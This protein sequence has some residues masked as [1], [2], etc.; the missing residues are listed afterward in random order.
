MFT[1]TYSVCAHTILLF[2]FEFSSLIL[3]LL[4]GSEKH[5]TKFSVFSDRHSHSQTQNLMKKCLLKLLVLLCLASAPAVAQTVSGRVTNSAD[6]TALPGVSVLVKG[7]SSGTTTDFDGKYTIGAS[8]PNAVLVFSFIGFA[9]QEIPLGSRTSVDVVLEEDIT[10]LG[11]VVVTALGIAKESKS[12]GYAV[13]KVEGASMTQ[14]REVNFVNSLAGRVAGVS[15]SN[16]SGGPGS[17]SNVRIRG[18]SSMFSDNSPLYVINGVPINNS[19]R[20]SAGMWGGADLGDGI[21]NI[22]PDDIEEMTVLKGS[23]ASAL[24][25]SRAANGVVVIT[26]KKGKAGAPVVEFNSNYTVDRIIDLTDY[27]DQYGQGTMGLK[28]T[29]SDAAYHAG[30]NSWGGKLDGSSVPQFDGIS[31]PY[32]AQRDNLKDFY[33]T[34]NTFTNTIALSAGNDFTSFRLSVSDLNN[35][36]VVPNSGLHRNTFNISVDQ[37]INSKFKASLLANYINEKSDNRP[38][39]SDSPGNS[40]FG[41]MFLPTSMSHSVLA[42]GFDEDGAE[43]NHTDNVYLTNPYFAANRF[44]NDLG[45]KRLISALTLKYDITKDLYIQGRVTRDS[46]NDRQ[47]SI[48]PTGTAYYPKGNMTEVASEGTDL[49]ADV[50]AAYKRTIVSDLDADLTV[51]ANIR[52]FDTEIITSSGDQFSIPFLHVLDNAIN[53]N[54][55]Y[56]NPRGEVQSWY[57]SLGFSYKNT[58]FLNTTGRKDYFSTL[59]S[60]SNSLFYPSV[61]ASVVFSEWISSN[62]F[63]FG[64]LRTSWAQTSGMADPY[65]TKLYYSIDQSI[66]G[67]PIGVIGGNQVPNGQLKPYSLNEFELGTE[68]K[69]LENRITFDVAYFSRKTKD[70]IVNR[71]VSQTS[72]YSSAVVNLGEWQNKGVELMVAADIVKTDKF[73]WNLAFNFTKMNSE[74][75]KLSDIA[76]DTISQL[77]QSRTQ[78]AYVSQVVGEEISQVMAYDFLRNPSGDII[79]DAA[80]RPQR[81]DL[82]PMGSGMHHTY[83]G[84]NNEFTYGPLKFGFLIDFKSG[85]KIFSAT[86][87]Y[88]TTFGLHKNTLAG[89]EENVVYPGVVAVPDPD[90]PTAPPTY[91]ANTTGVAAWDY[92]GALASNV[93]SK[94]V[95]DASFVKLRQVIIGYQ[96]PSKWLDGTPVRS[97][98]ISF[99][100]RNLAILKKHTP[101]VDPES[102]FTNGNAQGLELAGVPTT[103]NYGFNLNVKF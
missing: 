30:I 93:S 4:V 101:N 16:V 17:S 96:L 12:L 56:N 102:N 95:Y 76:T 51:G 97:V 9:S 22:N 64:K 10:Q 44:V 88:A 31:R 49:N 90:D 8:D 50:L 59:P 37:K 99:V 103:R 73:T 33:N 5:Q 83:G 21:G 71:P 66:N 48:T 78:N 26:T 15:I 23:T 92:Y 79:Y 77:D 35:N 1:H 34:G 98:N 25:G 70:E 75:L 84:I 94:F 65:K 45:R 19:T 82:R 47:T 53:K 74:V 41:I 14:A 87:S 72:G 52:K 28:P 43:I 100:G 68:M 58:V 62:V 80:G 89:R 57:Y 7:T 69:F 18:G 86:N 81:G 32:V 24:Y 36:S 11:E 61:G 54:A 85:G 63:S 60:A 42:P 91:T 3:D 46:Y 13:T 2:S 20:G 40:N 29:D 6:G 38:F 39:L 67:Y 27:Q 55:D